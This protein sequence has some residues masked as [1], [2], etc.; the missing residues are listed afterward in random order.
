MPPSDK[1]PFFL[2]SRWMYIDR[3]ALGFIGKTLI[4]MQNIYIYIYIYVYIYLEF[5][6]EKIH[7]L[8]HLSV[9][10]CL[11]WWWGKWLSQYFNISANH[12]HYASDMNVRKVTSNQPK[13][14]TK[15]LKVIWKDSKPPLTR[16]AHT[17]WSQGCI[18]SGKK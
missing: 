14:Q 17:P 9:Q 10:F 13:K 4:G 16:A 3:K 1:S 15:N 6:D 18:S 11:I 2:M 8:S 12:Y 5:N 7:I